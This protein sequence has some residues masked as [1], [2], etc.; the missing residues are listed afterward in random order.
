VDKAAEI[1]LQQK[2]QGSQFGDHESIGEIV[3]AFDSWVHCFHA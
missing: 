2:L 3:V 1:M